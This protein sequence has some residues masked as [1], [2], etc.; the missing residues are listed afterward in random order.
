[1]SGLIEKRVTVV[2]GP[3]TRRQSF[4][5]AIAILL[6]MALAAGAFVLARVID[7]TPRS[8]RLVGTRAADVI[9]GGGGNDFIAGRRGRDRLIGRRGSDVLRGGPGRDR[10]L[11]GRGPDV[12]F[13]G[14]GG[15]AMKGGPGFDSS[16][17]STGWR[18]RPR[19]GAAT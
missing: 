14:R 7:G 10:L 17:A 19:P 11:G 16:M 2:G 12:L 13:A 18:R 1:M 5:L 15:A 8:D 6:A 9:R 4:L 3:G